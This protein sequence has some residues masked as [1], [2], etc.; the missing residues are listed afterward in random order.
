[1][2][3]RAFGGRESIDEDGLFDWGQAASADALQDAGEKHDVEA[4]GDAAEERCDGEEG[5]AGH[6]VIFSAEDAGEP[7]GHREDDSVCYEVVRIQVTSSKLRP[8]PPA[9]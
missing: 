2:P 7:R 1:M 3:P 5:D 8:R 4:G 6:V 9:M